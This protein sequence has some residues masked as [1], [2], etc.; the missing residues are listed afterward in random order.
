MFRDK[1]GHVIEPGMLVV[2]PKTSGRSALLEI[3]TVREIRDGKLYLDDSHVAIQYPGRLLV[4]NEL[5]ER[6]GK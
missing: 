6:L 3:R 2:K 4:I 1:V 5:K